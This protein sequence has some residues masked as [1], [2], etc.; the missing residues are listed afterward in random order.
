MVTPQLTPQLIMSAV[1]KIEGDNSQYI[2]ARAILDTG[3]T[4]N[5]ITDSLIERIK[6]RATKLS[7][8]ISALNNVTT[9]SQGI[10]NIR[11]KSI[12]NQ[13]EREL[14]C[15][16]I[17][18][19]SDLVPTERFPR[20]RLKIP[21]NIKLADPEFHIP[22]PV[23]LL[24]GSGVTTSLFCVGQIRLSDHNEDAYAQKTQ[25]GWVIVGGISSTKPLTPLCHAA[26]IRRP[27]NIGWITE[28]SNSRNGT[29]KDLERCEKHFKDTTRRNS[30]G[31]YVVRLPF[32]DTNFRLGDSKLMAMRR[33]SSLERK[34]NKNVEFKVKYDQ[35]LNEYLHL[36]HAQICRPK[37]NGGYYMPHHAVIKESSDTTKVR[38]VFDAS[39][40]SSN[41][42]SLNEV[43][44]TGP[45]IQKKLY[46]HLIRFRTYKYVATADIEKMYRQVLVHNSD[47]QFQRFLWRQHEQIETYQLKTL[48][49]GISSSPYLAIRVLHQ[50]ADDE[51]ETHP[52]AAKIVKEHL[53]VDDLLTGAGS[54]DELRAIR[55]DII[56]LLSK[57]GFKIRQWAANSPDILLGITKTDIHA[58]FTI[59]LNDTL[60]TLGLNWDTR[61]DSFSYSIAQGQDQKLP[62]KRN[63]LSKI[64]SIFDPLGL[65]G[66]VT[67]Y[68]KKIMQDVWRHKLNWDE[69]V[70]QKIYSDWLVFEKQLNAINETVFERKVISDNSREIQLHGFCDA[71]GS[72]FGA[73]IYVRCIN[74]NGDVSVK[75][76][77][78]KSRVAPLKPTTIPRLELS[79]ALLLSKLCLEATDALQC[80]IDNITLWSDST[81]VLQWIQKS[82]NIL[83]PYVANRVKEIQEMTKELQWR[84]VR[85][86][87]NPADIISRGQLPGAL[88]NNHAWFY[89]PAW[90]NQ[91]K[92]EWPEETVIISEVPELR[93]NVCLIIVP[94]RMD[95]LKKYS[96]Y[97][98]LLRIIAYCY[99]FL[100]RKTKI[101]GTLQPDE[102]D[103]AERWVIKELQSCV[104]NTELQ[105]LKTRDRNLMGKFAR[106]SPFL[107]EHNIIRVG[108]RLHKSTLTFAQKHPILLPGS[109]PLTDAIIRETHEKNFHTGVLTTL[110]LIR[111]NFWILDGR[112][113]VRKVINKCVRCIRFRPDTT[114][115]KMG[116]LPSSR[117]RTALPFESTGVDFCG[118]FYTKERKYRNKTQVKTY[119]CVFVCMTMKAIHLEAV[120]DL[121]SDGFL[122]ALRRFV[123]RRGLPRHIHSDNG[124]NFVGANNKLKELYILLN[125]SAHKKKVTEF[126]S[127]RRIQWH[128]IPPLSPHFGGLWEASVKMF[129]HHFKRV[130]GNTV[131]TLEQ[132]N[133]FVN[134]IEA[135]LNSRPMTSLSSDPNDII[136]LTP[137]H[138]LIGRTFTTLP[139]SDFSS[140]NENRLAVW[141]HLSKMRQDFWK[142]WNLEY[143]N[144]LQ[145]RQKW[146][147]D[148]PVLKVGMVVLIKEKHVPCFNWNLGRIEELHLG[149]D[150]IARA[151]TIKTNAGKIKRTTKL[152]CPLPTETL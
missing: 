141:Q 3:S 23:D 15:L 82:P 122:A 87:N 29:A 13:Y 99:R 78:A 148:G 144:S 2:E 92:T 24:L 64:A 123:A 26:N 43:L 126:A 83:K 60:K 12:V 39:A 151:A 115:Y 111:Q 20:H 31:R 8:P 6:S 35:V 149:E 34:L 72:A 80:R 146:F 124:T 152:L 121:S 49:F 46:D 134:E 95:F 68:A 19:I 138:Y 45:T 127:E 17:P 119:V 107:D 25:L 84:H 33:L 106:L 105:Q 108:G 142:T 117:V 93:K 125:S 140:V 69:S 42:L 57:G 55:D 51:I 110:S 133:T 30:D 73:C 14:T 21:R 88:T 16:V 4:A 63:I 98:K 79:G 7:L 44:M 109:H 76:L 11:I 135:V 102:I 37:S 86:E 1:V 70:P 56:D 18:T 75:L 139:E 136:A 118:P 74:D 145:E 128:F 150:G 22:R 32:R 48:T 129:K 50:L 65:I 120:T 27:T 5:F 90:L 85:S 62:T 77:C 113:R 143:L 131:F 10:I 41:G 61:T 101:K 147:K 81:I 67:L 114:H 52:R 38:V 96:S 89:G 116:N 112:N 66:P 137:A 53:Y 47:Q 71:S 132:F 28:E 59:K 36:E 104:F 58:N 130:V 54:I 9:I 91:A 103:R 40:K 94:E 97:K 100:S